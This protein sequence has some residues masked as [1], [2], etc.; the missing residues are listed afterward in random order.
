MGRK[1]NPKKKYQHIIRI[2]KEDWEFL[3]MCRRRNETISQTADRLM[4][5]VKEQEDLVKVNDQL[6]RTLAAMQRDLLAKE[7]NLERY[8]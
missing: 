3:N 4:N 5:Y 8:I 2:E 1:S 6:R 7:G